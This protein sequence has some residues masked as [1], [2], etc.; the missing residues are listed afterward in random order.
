VRR[1]AVRPNRTA[2]SKIFIQTGLSPLSNHTARR[3]R[4][5]A[6]GFAAMLHGPAGLTEWAR[7][8]GA[9]RLRTPLDRQLLNQKPAQI[10]LPAP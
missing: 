10:V 3:L 1:L 6:A 7:Q 8:P 2:G 5:L 9:P 4:D